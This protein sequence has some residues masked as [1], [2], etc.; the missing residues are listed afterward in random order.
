MSFLPDVNVQC[1]SCEGKRFDLETLSI[2]YRGKNIT[3]VLN[4]TFSEASNFFSG[5]PRTVVQ[6]EML[7]KQQE[8][9]EVLNLDVPF[10][11]IQSRLAGRWTHLPS[12]RVYNND[13]NPPKVK[14]GLF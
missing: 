6:A 11:T 1:E 4:M 8:I 2:L 9:D 5:F 12:G 7:V 10:E 14:V 3:D 13:F